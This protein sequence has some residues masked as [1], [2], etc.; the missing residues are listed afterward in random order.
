MCISVKRLN[1]TI[2]FAKADYGPFSYLWVFIDIWNI[3]QGGTHDVRLSF[4]TSFSDFGTMFLL[5]CRWFGGILLAFLGPTWTDISFSV[6]NTDLR[7]ML[8]LI[9]EMIVIINKDE[10]SSKIHLKDF[11]ASKKVNNHAITL[12][13]LKE[14]STSSNQ[15]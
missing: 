14:N 12:W 5:G 13:T 7:S 10:L 4:S 8:H 6:E 2:L 9:V 11:A 15:Q 1:V 3:S